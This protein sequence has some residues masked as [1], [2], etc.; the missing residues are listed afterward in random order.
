[1]GPL[2]YVVAIMGCSDGSAGCQVVTRDTVRYESRVACMASAAAT[3]NR[4]DTLPYPELQ[5]R[6]ETRGVQMA[7]ATA[8]RR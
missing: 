1:M 6:C 2:V 8:S 7:D 3:L 4:Y 5:A